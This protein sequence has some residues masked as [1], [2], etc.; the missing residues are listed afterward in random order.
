MT[1]DKVFDESSGQIFV[2]GSNRAGIHG[3]GAARTAFREFG[4]KWEIGEGLTGQ[5]YALPTKDANLQVLKIEEIKAHVDKFI[6]FAKEH[7]ELE[8]FVTRVGCGLAGYTDSDISPLFSAAP[9]NCILP[10]GWESKKEKIESFR[11][12]YRFLS[13]FYTAPVSI[14]NVSYPSVEHAYQAMKFLDPEYQEKIRQASSPSIA[15][16]LGKSQEG[17]R[18]DWK[19]VKIQYMKYLV[20]TKFHDNPHL[21]ILLLGT[22]DKILEEGNT[23][24]DIF[25]GIC[26]G[27]GQNHLGKILMETRELLRRSE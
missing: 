2:F 15:K 5:S 24:G 4:A 10:H 16:N 17:R 12:A 18:V 9:G 8:F 20:W 22:E 27:A 11:G 3:A 7:P 14:Y 21:K 26:N 23:W 13:N 25:W 6:A 1:I 19:D